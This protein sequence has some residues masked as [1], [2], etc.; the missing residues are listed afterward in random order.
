M[1]CAALWRGA[2]MALAPLASCLLLLT[3]PGVAW[4]QGD[5]EPPIGPEW[6]TT[7]GLLKPGASPMDY[8]PANQGQ[9]KNFAKAARDEMFEKGMILETDALYLTIQGWIENKDNASDYSPV[10]LGQLKAV[11]K[12]FYDVMIGYA[13]R[14]AA[15]YP[16]PTP[17]PNAA[18]YAMAN[19]GQLKAVFNFAII[20]PDLDG[21]GMNDAWERQIVNASTTDSLNAPTDVLPLDDY[22]GDRIP[23]LWEYK[24]GTS[25]VNAASVP[26]FDAEVV[27]IPGQAMSVGGIAAA[28]NSLQEG[29]YCSIVLVRRGVH[30]GVLSR[31]HWVPVMQTFS[32][33][34]AYTRTDFEGNEYI[35]YVLEDVLRESSEE[36]PLPAKKVLWLGEG[37]ASRAGG[38]EGVVIVPEGDGMWLQATSVCDGLVFSGMGTQATSA[39]NTTLGDSVV[40]AEMRFNNCLFRR[41]TAPATAGAVFNQ[42]CHVELRHCTF[43]DCA[44][45]SQPGG[46]LVEAV[47]NGGTMAVVNSIL[48]HNGRIDT[49][50]AIGGSI[51][52]VTVQTS[53]VQGG[54]GGA[55][56]ESPE[57]NYGGY[58]TSE[59][60]IVV[61]AGMAG[62]LAHDIHGTAHAGTAPDLGANEWVNSDAGTDDHLPDWWEQWWTGDATL[63]DNGDP[64]MDTISNLDEFLGMTRPVKDQDGDGLDDV[65][66][67]NYWGNIYSQGANENPDMDERTNLQE[68]TD[69]TDPTQVDADSDV[70]NDGLMDLWEIHYWGNIESQDEDGNPDEDERNNLEEQAAG[71]NP[72][73]VDPDS[74]ADDDGLLDVWE[75]LH[76]DDI[77]AQDEDGNP[78]MDERN[79]LQEQA[80]GTDPNEVDADSDA[81]DDGLLDLWE[82]QYF[83]DIAA[84]DGDGNPDMD[85]RTNLEEQAAGTDPTQ[86]DTDTDTD[87]DGLPDLWETEHWG[88]LTTTHGAADP[89]SDGLSNFEEQLLGTSPI[90][91]TPL[92]GDLDND[93]FIDAWELAVFGTLTE[94]KLTDFN[95]D[96]MT[97]GQR[98]DLVKSL[99]LVFGW[100]LTSDSDSDGLTLEQEWMIGTNPAMADT[101]G[102]GVNDKLDRSPLDPAIS[103]TPGDISGPPDVQLVAPPG[104]ILL[105]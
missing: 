87:D 43:F 47:T 94:S 55:L 6:W 15:S 24:R 52:D 79:N 90:V 50:A 7:R 1:S 100:N 34:V 18:D 11:A 46:E 104:A 49:D 102:D 12:P 16:W 23:N 84:Q 75:I 57:L 51:G 96:G 54:L 67:I 71:T 5:P 86:L 27:A 45:I 41:C 88:N 61:D 93:G 62:V 42:G 73:Q 70:D 69:G 60:T 77:D 64:D 99:A 101:D 89:D 66:E 20:E 22:D 91:A 95:G 63:A 44:G 74:D 53:L 2:R 81:D 3:S 83:D 56:N 39:V 72:K 98:W 105:P 33:Y 40:S 17:S 68:Q 13:Q 9:L 14:E 48:W 21:D 78:D 26:G 19:I 8:A 31:T 10:N 97:N 36:R 76:F 82:I 37:G 92:T 38:Q 58:L 35:E 29:D 59:S 80:A 32:E 103:T 4:A 28:Y 25:P 30:Q 65:W 85:E